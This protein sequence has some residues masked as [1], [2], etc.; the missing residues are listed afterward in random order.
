M[1]IDK[2]T[3]KDRTT[4][5]FHQ[6]PTVYP[7]SHFRTR[8][9]SKYEGPAG[10]GLYDKWHDMSDDNHLVFDLQPNYDDYE[11]DYEEKKEPL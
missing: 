11:D 8:R 4:L 9:K 5:Y 10:S 3:Y 1:Y 6:G 7:G 2:L